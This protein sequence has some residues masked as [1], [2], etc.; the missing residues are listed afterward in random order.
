MIVDNLDDLKK[1]CRIN[2]RVCPQPQLWNE[3]WNRLKDKT[4]IGGKWEPSLPLILAAWW[5][6]PFL[7]KQLRLMEHLEWADNKGQLPE[8]ANFLAILSEDQWYHIND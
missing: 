2:Y 1:Y 4:Q 3:L 6:T 8:I 7:L 5:D